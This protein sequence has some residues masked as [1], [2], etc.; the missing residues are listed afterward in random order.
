VGIIAFVD[1]ASSVR[2][3][4]DGVAATPP[5]WLPLL[6]IVAGCVRLMW[7][8]RRPW[9]AIRPVAIILVGVLLGAFGLAAPAVA[10]AGAR[11]GRFL[12]PAGL[13]AAGIWITFGRR[14]QTVLDRP[15]ELRESIWLQGDMLR[16]SSCMLTG[17]L[18]VVLGYLVLDLRRCEPASFSCAL[19]L[20]VILGH[21]RILAPAGV[22]VDRRPAFVV[23][24]GGLQYQS[25]IAAPVKDDEDDEEATPQPVVHVIGILGDA[26]ITSDGQP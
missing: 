26:H 14:R 21:V 23:A 24:S 18:R 2:V 9:E 17:R 19:D 11:Y 7:F 5:W 20:T 10:A 16:P 8:T 3:D 12:W 6:I 25:A 13:I 4:G 22:T 1:R 15:G